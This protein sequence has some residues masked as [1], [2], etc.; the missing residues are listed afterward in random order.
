ML[1]KVIHSYAIDNRIIKIYTQVI[2]QN[3]DSIK[4]SVHWGYGAQWETKIVG[5]YLIQ[6][7]Q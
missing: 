4:E 1:Y 6:L 7:P 5:L 2:D 3:I